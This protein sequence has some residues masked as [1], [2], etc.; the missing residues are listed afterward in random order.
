[1]FGADWAKWNGYMKVGNSLFVTA[2]TE[3][4][5]FREGEIDLRIGKI[6]FLGDVNEN[7]VKSIT[8]TMNINALDENVADELLAIVEKSPGKVEMVFDIFDQEH[9]YRVA[10]A[11]RKKKIKIEKELIEF[12]D[13]HWGLSYKIN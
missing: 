6:E 7:N 9:N 5:R 10:L 1:L 13:A 8:I 3:P 11:S 2:R 4:H 12:I